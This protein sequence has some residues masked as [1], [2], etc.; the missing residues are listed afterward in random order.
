M[1][2]AQKGN[3]LIWAAFDQLMRMD[4]RAKLDFMAWQNSFSLYF[5]LL[6]KK[7]LF[8]T[9]LCVIVTV[10]QYGT[11]DICIAP[12]CKFVVASALSEP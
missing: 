12:E 10:I 4:V 2:V 5:T 8:N 3:Q 9:A 6:C 1:V 11:D 7:L